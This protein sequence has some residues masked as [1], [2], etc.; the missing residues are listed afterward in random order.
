[1]LQND[2]A[3]RLGDPDGDTLALLGSTPLLRTDQVG[4]VHLWTDGTSL[5][6]DSHS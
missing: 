4:T 5:W 6:T 3:N 1:V 2:P